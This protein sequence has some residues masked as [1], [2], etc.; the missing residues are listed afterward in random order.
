MRTLCLPPLLLALLA[1]C[2]D[3]VSDDAATG[4]T[5]VPS[6]A[7]R[8]LPGDAE[9]RSRIDRAIAATHAR[10]LD[11]EVNNA[12][13][14]VHAVLCFGYDL[15]LTIDG[16]RVP[17][18]A[19]I[20]NDSSTDPQAE[21][22]L[23]GWQFTPTTHG[24]DSS[25]QPGSKVGAGHAD[26]WLGY[27]S[28]VPQ[29]TLDTSL[30]Y[31]GQKYTIRN[32]VAEAKW[33]C[34]RNTELTWTL[35][36]LGRYLSIDDTWVASDGQTWNLERLVH[37][38]AHQDLA[39]SACGGSHRVFGLLTA[40]ANYRRARP[41]A[42]LT[43]A[44]LEAE[45]AVDNALAAIH[46]HQQPDG[47]FSQNYFTRA[48]YARDVGDRI[49]VTGHQLE[50]LVHALEGPDLAE[51]WIVRSVVCLCELLAAADRLELECGGLYHGVHGLILYREKRFGKPSTATPDAADARRVP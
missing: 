24:L 25:V 14:I 1:G 28:I 6:A 13:Q 48:S 19:W 30:D 51:P 3:I 49:S 8:P 31:R 35:M 43:G 40:L 33:H 38:E 37:F 26:Q 45:Q 2:V 4:T 27:C 34:P 10:V 11:P 32:L 50:V 5:G 36:A 15:Q 9:L 46:D 7:D 22:R 29:V 20:L 21:S 41:A 16:Q 12:W 23:H 44:W 42:P 47:S 18:L 39:T 17:G